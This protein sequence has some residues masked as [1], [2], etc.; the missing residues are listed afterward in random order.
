MNLQENID[1][2]KSIMRI[3]E[4]DAILFIKRRMDLFDKYIR[5]SYDWLNP[6]AF[7]S[8]HEFIDRVLFSASRDMLAEHS[9]LD[10]DLQVK[11]RKKI[12]PIL[13]DYLMNHEELYNEVIRYYKKYY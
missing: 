1:R 7:D 11:A 2:I 9:N 10:Y 8:I 3:D 4:N 12:S 5:I 13:K 6:G